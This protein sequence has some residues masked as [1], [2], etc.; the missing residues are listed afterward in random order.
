MA[1]SIGDLFV[2]LGFKVDS[3]PLQDFDKSIKS[4]SES[5]KQFAGMAGVGLSVAGFATMING[6]ADSAIQVRNLR[7]EL[8][9]G[10]DAVRGFAAAWHTANPNGDPLAGLS[11]AQNVGRY[12]VGAQYGERNE[13][14]LLGLTGAE[15]T[16][17]EVNNRVRANFDSSVKRWGISKVTAAMQAVYG[18]ADAVN[19]LRLSTDEYNESAKKGLI[20]PEAQK[21]LEDYDTSIADLT[22]SLNQL[23]ASWLSMPAKQISDFLK[24]PDA[25]AHPGIVAGGALLGGAGA[26]ATG[27][28]GIISALLAAGGYS[29]GTDIGN[30][31]KKQGYRWNPAIA[32]MPG[33]PGNN[34]PFGFYKDKGFSNIADQLRSYGWGDDQ[35]QGALAHLSKETAGFNP[36]AYGSGKEA[37]GMPEEAYGIGQWHPDRQADF[38]AIMGHDIHGSSREDQVAFM[39]YEL[40]KG[41]E[42]KAGKDFFGAKGA[43][44]AEDVFNRE[45]ER[46]ASTTINITNHN[47][48][49]VTQGDAYSQGVIDT[50]FAINSHSGF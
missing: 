21:N 16:L 7:T 46:S 37:K 4:V 23:K 31:L 34:A 8:G 47:D 3:Q 33:V 24:T 45:Y 38:L 9:M 44:N 50:T 30:T 22:N 2:S 10:T 29:V 27:W 41:K 13:G 20:S 36:N 11:V 18:T 40:S 26:V 1:Q 25:Q 15:K 35:I 48:A 12:I 42:Q 14:V 43:D 19:V 5:V 6:F 28:Y 49:G 32:T 17:D 39:N